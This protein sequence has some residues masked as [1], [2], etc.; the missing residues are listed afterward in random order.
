[1]DTTGGLRVTEPDGWWLPPASGTEP[2]LTIR[3]EAADESG[4]NRLR[5]ALA[6]HLRACGQAWDHKAR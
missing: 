2:K 1:V 5:G 6:G 3:C 4:L